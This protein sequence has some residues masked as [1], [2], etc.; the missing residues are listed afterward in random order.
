MFSADCYLSVVSAFL[1]V[2]MAGMSKG[3]E[4]EQSKGVRGGRR[5]DSNQVYHKQEM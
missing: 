3:E 4:V 1:S 2:M 5:L